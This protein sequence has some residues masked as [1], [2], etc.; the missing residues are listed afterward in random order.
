MD[1]NFALLTSNVIVESGLTNGKKKKKD[2]TQS[3]SSSLLE[4]RHVSLR[5]AAFFREVIS[6]FS[7]EV[8]KYNI[9]CNLL[10]KEKKKKSIL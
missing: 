1:E 5:M 3:G 4:S 8:E 6:N 7:N 9:A 10:K 2:K